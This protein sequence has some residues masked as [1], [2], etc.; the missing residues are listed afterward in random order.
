MQKTQTSAK[1]TASVIS[2]VMAVVLLATGTFAWYNMEPTATTGAGNGGMGASF[3]GSGEAWP[4]EVSLDYGLKGSNATWYKEVSILD[5]LD[6]DLGDFLL[7]PISTYDLQHWY[8]ATYDAYDDVDGFREVD[9]ADVANRPNRFSKAGGYEETNNCLLYVDLWVRTKNSSK[10]YDLRL[11]NPG[12]TVDDELHVD[13]WETDYG[14]FVTWKPTWDETESKYIRNDDAMASIRVGFLTY[15]ASEQPV[16][17][18]IYEPN[19]D[20]HNGLGNPQAAEEQIYLWDTD[21]DG[22]ALSEYAET[23]GASAVTMVPQRDAASE[24]GYSMAAQATLLQGTT[25]WKDAALQSSVDLGEWSSSYLRDIGRFYW[26]GQLI[27]DPHELPTIA[28]NISAGQPPRHIRVFFWLEGQDPDCWN[29]AAGDSLYAN[30]E[31]GAN[32]VTGFGN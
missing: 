29:M 16:Q 7:R 31:F 26:D 8:V 30:L 28:Q 18:L 20:L 25:H 5:A 19:A 24:T 15:D 3:A 4:F 13:A 14:T 2:L 11:N 1:L 6:A 21:N 23:N 32:E 17:A 27:S 9:L 12:Y 10:T 22:V